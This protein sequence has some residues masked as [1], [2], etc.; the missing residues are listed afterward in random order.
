VIDF[1]LHARQSF[2]DRS[3][4]SDIGGSNLINIGKVNCKASKLRHLSKQIKKGE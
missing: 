2:Q 4:K 3:K 1:F